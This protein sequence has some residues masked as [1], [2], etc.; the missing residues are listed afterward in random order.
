MYVCVYIHVCIYIYTHFTM[1]CL[2]VNG[3]F[4]LFPPFGYCE[5]CCCEHEC[6]DIWVP[7]FN[8][9]GYIPRIGIAGSYGNSMFNF[10]R[11]CRTVFYGDYI[12][13]IPIS[14][15]RGFQFLYVLITN[16]CYFLSFFFIFVFIKAIL[17]AMEWYLIVLI[18]I[19]LMIS[20]FEHLFMCLLV[21]SISSVEKCLF[22]ALPIF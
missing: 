6:T 2:F 9:F 17:I 21:I 7:A 13:Y 10:L 3:H 4:R 8:S 14:N 5:W 12:I 16:T 22:K 1:F 15:V 11:N 19:S 18:C 20:D